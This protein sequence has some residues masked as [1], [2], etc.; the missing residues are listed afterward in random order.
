M[1]NDLVNANRVLEGL[2][3]LTMHPRIMES[4]QAHA[5]DMAERGYF[6]HV[7]KKEGATSAGVPLVDALLADRF[8]VGSRLAWGENIANETEGFPVTDWLLNLLV[9]GDGADLDG[10]MQSPGHRANILHPGFTLTGFGLAGLDREETT[11]FVQHFC[12]AR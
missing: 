7:Y 1:L 5:D 9:N 8:C 4:A 3:P 12:R 10:W 6:E 11:Y 2:E